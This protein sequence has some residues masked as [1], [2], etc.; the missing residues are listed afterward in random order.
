MNEKDIA[1]AYDGS[2]VVAD[3]IA[4]LNIYRH[5]VIDTELRFFFSE[6]EGELREIQARFE[7]FADHARQLQGEEDFDNEPPADASVAFC[8]L[9]LR[10]ILDRGKEKWN[11][12]SRNRKKKGVC[13]HHTG[14]HPEMG[15][16]RSV[17][18]TWAGHVKAAPLSLL[19]QEMIR[20]CYRIAGQ[21][22]YSGQSYHGWSARGALILNLPFDLRTW[23]GDGANDDYAGYA[24]DYHSGR[25]R[26]ESPAEEWVKLS[27]FIEEMRDEGHPVT[28]LTVHGAWAHKPVDPGAEVIRNVMEPVAKRMDLAI[29]YDF[30]RPG[31]TSI[32][33]MLE[34][35]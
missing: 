35:G 20:L 12:P 21:G 1:A 30:K 27:A 13:I 10:H 3:A 15:V 31:C 24:I 28:E 19:T 5:P 26:L 4:K 34:A 9:D 23:H 18:S 8:T 29:A 17:P 11:G 14:I 22:D 33:E 2:A 32:R 25:G 7:H 6:V 16:P